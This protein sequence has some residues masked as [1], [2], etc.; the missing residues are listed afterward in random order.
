MDER[1]EQKLALKVEEL[2]R[3][4]TAEELIEIIN[5]EPDEDDDGELT[6]EMDQEQTL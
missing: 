2:G 6:Y 1:I 5:S 3:K 4:L